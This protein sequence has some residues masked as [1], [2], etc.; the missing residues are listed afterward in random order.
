MKKPKFD[1]AG[2]DLLA[3]LETQ[4]NT[5]GV[6]PMVYE[7]CE[8]ADRLAAVRGEIR[9]AGVSVSGGRNILLDQEVK[10]VA[11]FA[12]YWRLLGLAESDK[13]KVS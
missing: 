4:F 9:R 1:R 11:A 10:I 5:K 12:R 3:W 6:E 2:S 7:L 13:A 8:I